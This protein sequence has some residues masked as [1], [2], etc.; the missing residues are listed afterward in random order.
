MPTTHIAFDVPPH[1]VPTPPVRRDQRRCRSPAVPRRRRSQTEMKA[2][3]I[4]CRGGGASGWRTYAIRPLV[5]HSRAAWRAPCG[6]PPRYRTVGWPPCRT[7]GGA[8]YRPPVCLSALRRS[9]A[10]CFRVSLNGWTQRWLL[11]FRLDADE[12]IYWKKSVWNR[13][14]WHLKSRP[15]NGCRTTVSPLETG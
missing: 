14:S 4:V 8:L 1:R 11:P 15:N 6:A 9:I 5:G 10:V 7:E 2:F 13:S 12:A 3:R